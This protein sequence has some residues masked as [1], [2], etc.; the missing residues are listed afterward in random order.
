MLPIEKLH[1][2]AI[3]EMSP[4]DRIAR[5]MELFNW[6]RE[7]IARQIRAENEDAS[8]ESIKLQVAIRMYGSEPGMKKILEGLSPD[9]SD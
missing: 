7:F 2:S 3:D 6:S 4:K 9:V 5:S 8:I 1:Q